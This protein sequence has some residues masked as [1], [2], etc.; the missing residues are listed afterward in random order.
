VRYVEVRYY[1]NIFGHVFSLNIC[2]IT[3]QACTYN[4]TLMWIVT[5]AVIYPRD[6]NLKPWY[7]CDRDRCIMLSN[8]F[9]VRLREKKTKSTRWCNGNTI[10]DI[11]FEITIVPTTTKLG[12]RALDV[13]RLI[14]TSRSMRPSQQ[15]L[16][17]VDSD[18]YTRTKIE[19]GECIDKIN[20]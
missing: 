11:N 14:E 8:S 12:Q 5:H 15:E 19:P 7:N 17:G 3:S 20:I 13:V 9:I 10:I 1:L 4:L 18:D 16:Q 2:I 6:W